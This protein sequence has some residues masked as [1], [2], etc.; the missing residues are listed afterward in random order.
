MKQKW[1]KGLALVVAASLLGSMAAP[2]SQPLSG[3]AYAAADSLE[4]VQIQAQ[5]ESTDRAASLQPDMYKNLNCQNYGV[6][7]E[8]VT[9]YLVDLGNGFMRLQQV[10]DE[11]TKKV[12]IE[13]YDEQYRLQSQRYMDTQLDQFA[14]FYAGNGYYYIV[15]IQYLHLLCTGLWSEEDVFMRVVKYDKDW[16]E[17]DSLDINSVEARGEGV[18]YPCESGSLRMTEYQGHLYVNTCREGIS[19][20]Q[21]SM[22]FDI[23]EEDMTL[24]KPE[25]N[26]AE[27]YYGGASHTFNQFLLIDEEL[28]PKRMVTLHQCDNKTTGKRGAALEQSVLYTEYPEAINS[29]NIKL[30]NA[31]PC[32]GNS[33]NNYVGI[34]LGGLEQSE[35]SYLIAGTSI[36]QVEETYLKAWQRNIFVTAT[37]RTDFT[38]EHTSVTWLTDY[39]EGDGVTIS[40]PQFVK[41]N[42]NLFLVM[43]RVG[44]QQD[45]REG[46]LRYAFVDADGK[47][48]LGQTKSVV[49]EIT[50]CKPIVKNGRAIW[51]SSGT[52]G[53]YFYTIDERGNFERHGVNTME[54]IPTLTKFEF[55]EDGL[56]YEWEPVEHA[57]GYRIIRRR[58]TGMAVNDSMRYDYTIYDVDN[59]TFQYLDT[60]SFLD[61]GLYDV[62]VCALNEDGI[63][64]YGSNMESERLYRG[65]RNSEVSLWNVENGVQV[66]WGTRYNASEYRI[67]RGSADGTDMKLIAKVDGR[68]V[69]DWLGKMESYV[70]TTAQ[71]GVTY[72]Y[73]VTAVRDG[74]ESAMFN[75]HSIIYIPKPQVS[76]ECTVKNG[77]NTVTLSWDAVP[78]AEE[79]SVSEEVWDEAAG[80]YKSITLGHSMSE[81]NLSC[82]IYGVEEGMKYNFKVRAFSKSIQTSSMQYKSPFLS[83][84]SQTELTYVRPEG[85]PPL[86]AP[87]IIGLNSTSEGVRLAWTSMEGVDEYEL[88]IQGQQNTI[89]L[90]DTAYVDTNV[91][92]G[93]TYTYQVRICVQ[94]G[95]GRIYSDWSEGKSITYEKPTQPQLP[96]VVLSAPSFISMESTEEGVR[97]A[98]TPVEGA[99]G[100]EINAYDR[101]QGSRTVTR[102]GTVCEDL[103]AADGMTY[104]Y[105]VRAYVQ[106]AGTQIYSDWSAS[107]SFTYEKPVVVPEIQLQAPVINTCKNEKEGV[108]LAWNPIDGADGYE[109]NIRIKGAY[110]SDTIDLNDVVEYIDEKVGEWTEYEYR[111]RAYAKWDGEKLYYSDWSKAKSITFKKPVDVPVLSAPKITSVKNTVDGVKITWDKV[112]GAA[113]YYLYYYDPDTGKYS[114][115]KALS[116]PGYL[117][118]NVEVGKTYHYVVVAFV[119]IDGR[120]YSGEQSVVI[121]IEYKVPLLE[122]PVLKK[123]PLMEE[124][125][126]VEW[127]PVEGADG[128]YIWFYAE[129]G[130][131]AAR[132]FKRIDGGSIN[133]A[134]VEYVSR[135]PGKMFYYYVMAYSNRLGSSGRSNVERIGI[136]LPDLPPI[137]KIA[138]PKV[139]ATWFREKCDNRTDDYGIELT[140]EPVE[141]AE[142]YNVGFIENGKVLY[143]RPLKSCM[144]R[145]Y[146]PKEHEIYSFC[147]T[148][149]G[150]M[151]D[152][153]SY[154]SDTSEIA[155]EFIMPPEIPDPEPDPEPEPEP[156]VVLETPEITGL[157]CTSEGMEITWEPVEGAEGYYIRG[158]NADTGFGFQWILEGHDTVRYVDKMIKEG[159]TYIYSV[160]AYTDTPTLTLSQA[161]EGKSMVFI[162]PSGTTD[163]DEQNPNPA[164]DDSN[165]PGPNP[166][167]DPGPSVKLELG[168]VDGDGKIT[169]IDALAILKYDVKMK[170]E[171]FFLEAADCDGDGN[172]NAQDALEILKYDVHLITEFKKK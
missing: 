41:M 63:P 105:K 92:D 171:K 162:K 95:D 169:T 164:P 172:V 126:K 109:I 159:E 115:I 160:I 66:Q 56:Y 120:T 24:V 161:S 138:T 60:S 44:E 42:N 23:I 61:Y 149:Y 116:E 110:T 152:G 90:Q 133:S 77:R 153:R 151:E 16:N 100:Y 112:E 86:P 26:N 96:V 70:D 76:A 141:G 127:E 21:S 78:G 37:S 30:V 146:F 9:S 79:Y 132:G 64:S 71:S 10:K 124:G 113:G 43:W 168:D 53:V 99:D 94:N 54:E 69:Q 47:R 128:Y 85:A 27:Y 131:A 73:T 13:Y 17:L 31:F 144:D 28:E 102:D 170:Q 167:P 147:V 97:L 87:S 158:R 134:I 137:P 81:D 111:I 118:K 25:I 93:K 57:A 136:P 67:Y 18:V 6:Y 139:S 166:G 29:G 98:W 148:A 123:L 122:D 103:R 33:D 106:R 156:V 165:E 62:F 143:S 15:W 12:V 121:S 130:D 154:E 74:R 7:G 51:Y 135:T 142:G 65:F 35:T 3:E 157:R 45:H 40:T 59:Q 58:D 89:L 72:D 119:G 39:K 8:L 4:E 49:A 19:T 140:W 1:K 125:V 38:K 108:R 55:R 82:V 145:Y 83:E 117:D 163:P 32:V 34:S 2:F 88:R 14:G 68:N 20:H 91:Q 11:G 104:T 80:K 46:E 75:K 101:I 48:C 50:D 155:I 129:D 84:V 22:L 107:Q 150:H 5:A 114:I 36:D 52:E